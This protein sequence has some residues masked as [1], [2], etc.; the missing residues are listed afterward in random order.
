LRAPPCIAFAIGESWPLFGL[1]MQIHWVLVHAHDAEVACVL[2]P[3]VD[4]VAVEITYAGLP[5]GARL[6]HD[7]A[8]ALLWANGRRTE[9]LARGWTPQAAAELSLQ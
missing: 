9:W 3:L 8:D 6:C 1:I 4:G 7:E 5:V 2:R